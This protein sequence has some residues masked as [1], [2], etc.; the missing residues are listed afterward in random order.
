MRKS[1]VAAVAIV[2]AVAVATPATAA[3]RERERIQ[4][5]S[6]VQYVKTMFNK[7]FKV[8]ST[9]VP[10]IPFPGP[11]EQPPDGN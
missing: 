7:V 9:S 8:K 6:I 4:P 3:S 1:F 10:I 2:A 11:V 5:P